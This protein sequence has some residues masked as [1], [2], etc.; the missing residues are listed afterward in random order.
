MIPT[1]N[2]TTHSTDP[3]VGS[4]ARWKAAFGA[5]VVALLWFG[6]AVETPRAVPSPGVFGHSVA[7]A[8]VRRLL[9]LGGRERGTTVATTRV[10]DPPRADRGPDAGMA[11]VLDRIVLV[12]TALGRAALPADAE[13]TRP[14]LAFQP[15]GPPDVVPLAAA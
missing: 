11:P 9:L 5:L 7:D 6:I 14:A 2:D 1:S 4:T 13:P 3:S 10:S 15:R 8:A 12:E